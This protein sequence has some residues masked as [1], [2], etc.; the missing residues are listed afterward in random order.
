MNRKQAEIESEIEDL[1]RQ[2]T[3]M[4][5]AMLSG[6][7][8]ELTRANRQSPR[9]RSSIAITDDTVL[10]SETVPPGLS[11]REYREANDILEVNTRSLLMFVRIDVYNR[12]LAKTASRATILFYHL[13]LPEII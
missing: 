2:K 13:P 5:K 1:D 4:A 8:D 11:W 12:R 10:Y 7:T 6:G 9:T 3:M